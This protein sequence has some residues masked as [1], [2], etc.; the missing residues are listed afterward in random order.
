MC[1]TQKTRKLGHIKLP[2]EIEEDIARILND[3][4]ET[5]QEKG[6]LKSNISK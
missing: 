6:K 4:E 1:K 3:T 5:K 2:R